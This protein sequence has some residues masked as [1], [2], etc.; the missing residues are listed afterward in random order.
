[1]DLK[2]NHG[3]PVL[4]DPVP[5][6]QPRL[7]LPCSLAPYSNPLVG[8]AS[9]LYLT[10]PRKASI[11]G[12]LE[13]VKINGW[14]GSMKASSPRKKTNADFEDETDPEECDTSY[15]LWKVQY[16]SA[17]CFFDQI[18]TRAKGKR[19]LL[20]LDY[21]GTLS[22]IVNDPDLAFMS[23]AMR[24]AVNDAAK[25]F[26]TAIISGRSRNKVFDFV[27]L[28]ELYYAGSHGMD[29]TSPAQTSDSFNSRCSSLHSTRTQGKGAL[30]QPASRFIPMIDEVCEAL[31]NSTRGIKGTIVENNRFCC[32]VHYRQ[33]DERN[34][35][36]I[37]QTVHDILKGYPN[38]RLT[39]GRKVLE[40]RPVIDWDKGKAIEFLLKSLG[41]SMSDDILPIYIGDDR[42]DEDAFKVLRKRNLGFGILVSSVPKESS[43]SFSL[44]DPS[45]VLEFL[46]ILTSWR[47][48][49][50]S[51]D[52]TS[53]SNI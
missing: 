50:T 15:D 13:D 33:V 8:F 40:I 31:A 4:A 17:I 3:A 19:I 22:P 38:L 16:P 51:E 20:F 37:A 39:H 25:Y 2:T 1:M 5:A 45:E 32:S 52:N 44:K 41:L 49:S 23:P 18:A 7:V 26:S 35:P 12:M 11:T 43:A 30:F 21:D 36:V 46:K 34:W 42:T 6:S 47:K 53:Y 9:G 48:A 29:I 14:L 28:S 27:R 24:N 10:I